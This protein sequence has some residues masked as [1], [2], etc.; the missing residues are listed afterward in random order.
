MA[1]NPIRDFQD[2]GLFMGLLGVLPLAA[3]YFML[4]AG[5]RIDRAKRKAGQQ[6]NKP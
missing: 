5:L 2:M 3:G 1:E 4:R 6:E